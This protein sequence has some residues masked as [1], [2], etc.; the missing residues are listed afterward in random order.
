MPKMLC[1]CGNVL[2]YGDIPCKIE[3]KF[4]SDVDYDKYDAQIDSE[5]L[6]TKMQSFFK[7]PDCQRLWI[8]WDGFDNEPQEY[9]HATK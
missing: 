5:E 6:Y 8:F 2:R 9:L 7:C 3:Y 1:T 4:I